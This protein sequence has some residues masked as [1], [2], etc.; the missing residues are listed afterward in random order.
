MLNSPGL[1]AQSV[2]GVWQGLK[3]FE[4]EDIDTSKLAVANMKGIK[5]SVRSRD[6]AVQAVVACQSGGVLLERGLAGLPHDLAAG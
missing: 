2:E 6:R 1:T 3:V 5:R 4:S